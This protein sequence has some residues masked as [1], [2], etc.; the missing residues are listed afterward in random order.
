MAEVE[1]EAMEYNV[2]DAGVNESPV[3]DSSTSVKITNPPKLHA[4]VVIIKRSGSDGSVFPMIANKTTF[5]R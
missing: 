2:G 4:N 5:G 3:S 1:K